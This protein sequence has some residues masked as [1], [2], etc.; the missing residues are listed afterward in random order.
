MMAKLITLLNDK[1]VIKITLAILEYL[2]QKSSNKLDDE[3]VPLARQRLLP[4]E[5]T[6]KVQLK[7]A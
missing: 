4:K 7:K 5:P 2:V 1:T 6:A 3:V